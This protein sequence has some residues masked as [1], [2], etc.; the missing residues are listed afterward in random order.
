METVTIRRYRY[1]EI[2][3]AV[4]EKEDAGYEHVTPI[5]KVYKTGK[6]YKNVKQKINGLSKKKSWVY[7]GQ[8]DEF[9]Y[10]CVMRKVN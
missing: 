2:I 10:M 8:N 1:Q 3:K 6:Q 9:S 7:T 4:R 5:Q